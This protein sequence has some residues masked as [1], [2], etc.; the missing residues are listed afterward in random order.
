MDEY[1]SLRRTIVVY[2]AESI[3]ST[4]S[5]QEHLSRQNIKNVDWPRLGHKEF[6]DTCNL[7]NVKMVSRSQRN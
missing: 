6:C 1:S 2:A 5:I 4:G 3:L 7:L